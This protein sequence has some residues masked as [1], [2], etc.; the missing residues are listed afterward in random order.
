M[1]KPMV[2]SARLPAKTNRSAQE[3]ALPYF[4]LIG[5]QQAASLVEVAVVGPGVQRGE[6][7]GAGAA[8]AAAVVYAVGAGGMPAHADEEA[9]VVAKVG[10]PPGLGVGHECVDVAGQFV[11]VDAR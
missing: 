1:V 8:A 7:L 10:R 3:M 6:T 2:S 11:E 4:C 5:K 9:A